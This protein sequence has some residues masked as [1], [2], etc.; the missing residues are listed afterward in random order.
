M[1]FKLVGLTEFTSALKASVAAADAGS[2][3]AVVSAAAAVET[4]A[5]KK[6]TTSSHRKGT[7]TPSRPGQPP[8]LVTGQL[9]RSVRTSPPSKVGITA[10][11]TTVGPTAVYARIQELGGDTRWSTL[12]ARP[13]FAPSVDELVRNGALLAAFRAGWERA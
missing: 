9:R 10:W 13:Y 2:R 8:S 5:K 7:P 3:M 4:A 11:Q 1:T 12:P 6:L